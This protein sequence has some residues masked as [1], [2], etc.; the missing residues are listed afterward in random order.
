MKSRKPKGKPRGGYFEPDPGRRCKAVK[1]NGKPCKAWTITGGDYCTFHT[2]ELVKA[3]GLAGGA[4]TSARWREIDAACERLPLL[5]PDNQARYLNYL[6]AK[7]DDAGRPS[8]NL[9]VTLQRELRRVTE[10]NAEERDFVIVF[11]D[12][13]LPT[14]DMAAFPEPPWVSPPCPA[15]GHEHEPQEPDP[16][17]SEPS[18]T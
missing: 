13:Q 5:T 12:P 7:E 6:I 18:S 11:E 4:S 2:P 8:V 14:E 9:I 1:A 15:C 16:D 10:D 3:A 17:G